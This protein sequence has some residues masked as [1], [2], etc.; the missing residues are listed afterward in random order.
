M[1]RYLEL[2]RRVPPSKQE[3]V[4]Q[5]ANRQEGASAGSPEAPRRATAAPTDATP[6]QD[7]QALP[8]RT[9]PCL[10]CGVRLLRYQ[11][12]APPVTIDV[13]SVVV[14]VERFLQAELRELDARLHSPVQIRAGHGVFTILDRLRQIGV[15]LEIDPT[16]EKVQTES[17]GAS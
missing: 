16:F 1:G 2:A 4:R 10:P 9:L 8:S 6:R 3:A 12:K 15:E 17:N 11:P 7:D 13:C 14:D 5:L